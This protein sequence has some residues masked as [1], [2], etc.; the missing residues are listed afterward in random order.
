MDT[1]RRDRV[2]AYGNGNGLTPTLDGFAAHGVRFTQA[3]AHAPMTLPSHTAIL[4][5]LTP[6]R[7][8]VRN[9]TAFRLDDRVPTLATFLRRAGYRTGAFVGAFVLDARFGL[10]RDFDEYD[11]RLPLR[12]D[13]SFHFSERRAADVVKAAADWIEPP[14]PAHQ[15]PNPQHPA[16]WFAWVHLF[17]PHAP[18]D[19]PPEYRSGRSPYDA[20]VAY[21]DAM[22]GTLVARLRDAHQ[23]E[24]T[25]IVATADHGE[26]LGEHG[27][28]THGLFAYEATIAVPL[29]VSAPRLD[30]AIVDTPAG[31]VDVVPT[32]LD[33]AGIPVP[34]G[35]DG[36]SLARPQPADRAIEFE[37]LDAA[38]T[39]G[40]APLQ[41]LVQRGVKYIDLPE[42]EL[43]DLHADPAERTNIVAG[44]SRT[45]A[46]RRLLTN[47]EAA[48]AAPKASPAP[49]DSEAAARLRALGYVG[50]TATRRHAPAPQDDPKRL[51]AL[52]ERFNLA[53]TLFDS[54]RSGEALGEFVAVLRERPDFLTARTSA[55]VAL[56]N[57][58]RAREAADLLRAAPAE[59]QSSPE[60]LTRL[61]AALRD[62]GDLRGAAVA[63]EQARAAAPD[64]AD[65]AEDLATVYAAMRRTDAARA[66]LKDLVARN[67]G[68]SGAWY[69]LGLV[70]LQ[71]GRGD[72][73]AG[74]LQHAV[75]RQPSYGD[76]WNALGA[77]LVSRDKAA[78]IDAWVHAERL[79]PRD[80]DLLFNLGVVLADA[81]DA[82]AVPY[83]RRFAAEAPPE[84]YARDIASVRQRLAR[85]ER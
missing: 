59:Q 85:L 57:A 35:L 45:E 32:I 24:N 73:A 48:P 20:E 58:G 7:N 74:A 18:Y 5:G 54:G 26:S 13:P 68:M 25:L 2:G 47:L 60:L 10:A 72:A 42:P 27:E 21:A 17:D 28:T 67:P 15:G 14:A 39:R 84:R 77:A 22:L 30:A 29:I 16:P 49:V 19:A 4:T 70:E 3:R 50:G 56:M 62:A 52:S 44:D 31:H 61:G 33:L 43:Y 11:D 38:L 71:S 36:A 51:V 83:L 37:A 78:A 12:E 6:R 1:L 41:G 8:G 82:R 64:N 63:L 79:L 53:V 65:A 80:Y 55:A 66:L 69:N 40:W 81:N 76:A 9:N 34:Q 75:E 46:L 23:L